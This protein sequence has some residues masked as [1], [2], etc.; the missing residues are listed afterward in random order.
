MRC[1]PDFETKIVPHIKQ[2]FTALAG[3]SERL[4]LLTR[5]APIF[6]EDKS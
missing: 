3:K 6:L 5:Q 1:H 2:V 4:D